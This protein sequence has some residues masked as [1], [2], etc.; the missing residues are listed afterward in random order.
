[1]REYVIYRHGW[2]EANQSPGLGLPEKM[3]VAR[4]QADSPEEACQAAAGQIT[5]AEN[6]HLSAEPADVVDTK[7][8][9]LNRTARA[10]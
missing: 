2:N 3:A 10:P 9:D 6:Q 1:M 7:E 4:V 5:L 8:H